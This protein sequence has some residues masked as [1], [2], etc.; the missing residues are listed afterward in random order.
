MDVPFI[1][2]RVLRAH[3]ENFL[4]RYHPSLVIPIPIEVIVERDLK[5]QIVPIPGLRRTFHIDAFITSDF[6]EI[7]VDETQ[8]T[9]YEQRYRFTLAHEVGHLILHRSIYNSLD[10]TS[11]S[12]WRAAQS[13]MGNKSIGDLEYQANSFASYLLVPDSVLNDYPPGVASLQDIAD[14]FNVS[15]EAAEVRLRKKY[16]K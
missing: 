2:E 15:L 13:N 8:M 12:T 6:K 4:E 10:I 16:V 1:N 14:A 7:H 9:D 5:I 3:A 11:E